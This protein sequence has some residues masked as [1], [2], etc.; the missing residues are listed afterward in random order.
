MPVDPLPRPLPVAATPY[1]EACEP[2]EEVAAAR[3]A[4]AATALGF[5]LARLAAGLKA[6][7]RPLVLATTG[8]WLRERGRPFARGLA[9][10]GVAPD[11]LVWIR[12][13]REAEALW[14]LEE[15]LKSGA[16]AAALGC[17]AAPSFVATRRLDFAARAGAAVGLILRAGG[18]DDL[19]AARRR[20]RIAAQAS[21]EAAFDPLAPGAAR[22]RAELVRRRD[23]PPAAWDLE[24]CDET[25]GLRLV[26]GLAG[27]GVATRATGRVVAVA[28]E[29]A[30]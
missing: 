4:D 20:W 6:D 18:A 27:H 29:R 5:G 23:G 24:L 1:P 2:L 9:A 8:E 17:V 21:G 3:P 28:G 7:R 22:L 25:G 15:C 26:A 11:R 19:S 10:W 16:V 30:A 12:A 14:A 13:E